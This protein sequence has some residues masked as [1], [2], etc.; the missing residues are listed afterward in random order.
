MCLGNEKNPLTK[1]QFQHLMESRG[2]RKHFGMIVSAMDCRDFPR[3]NRFTQTMIPNLATL[4]NDWEKAKGSGI[5]EKTEWKEFKEFMLED[6]DVSKNF[7]DQIRTIEY[8]LNKWGGKM[9]VIIGRGKTTGQ[10]HVDK[11][12]EKLKEQHLDLITFRFG[13]W[14]ETL[15]GQINDEENVLMISMGIV[16][17]GYLSPGSIWA[18]SNIVEFI[19]TDWTSHALNISF[20]NEATELFPECKMSCLSGIMN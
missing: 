17:S 5:L 9:T 20:K 19:E 4:N 2:K 8:F 15:I 6:Y 7:E 10:M 11:L 1:E 12:K 18:P 14:P 16:T 13:Y 3:M